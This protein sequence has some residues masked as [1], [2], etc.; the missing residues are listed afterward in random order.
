MVTGVLAAALCGSAQAAPVVAGADLSGTQPVLVHSVL[1]FPT[2]ND[3]GDTAD[4]FHVAQKLDQ[5]IA[6]RLN[7]IGH[8]KITYFTRHLASVERAVDQD[9][10]LTEPQVSPP[11]DDAGKASPVAT[12]IGTDAYLIDRVESYTWDDT[13][14]KATLEVSANLYNTETGDGIAGIAVTGTGVGI[15]NSDEQISVTQYAIDDAAS[16]IV[17]EVNDAASPAP[18]STRQGSQIGSV[19]KG[20]SFLLALA[21]GAVLYVAFNHSS[22]HSSSSSTTSGGGGS[23]TVLSPP[24]GPQQ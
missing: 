23:T 21:A 10:S 7:T 2:A 18:T 3:G 16:Q 4:E 6:F 15:S 5:A 1:V 13:N 22:T 20:A 14:K 11:F 24:G 8:L 9:K 12:I 17:R 19:G